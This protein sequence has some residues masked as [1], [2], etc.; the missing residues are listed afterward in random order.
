MTFITINQ[1]GQGGLPHDGTLQQVRGRPRGQQPRAPEHDM[2]G[3]GR[4]TQGQGRGTLGQGGG[5]EGHSA[6]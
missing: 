2:R 4:G 1:T 6:P 3:Q 5:V